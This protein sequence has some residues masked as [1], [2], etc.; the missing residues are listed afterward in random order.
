MR[1]TTIGARLSSDHWALGDHLLTAPADIT[2]AEVSETTGLPVGL[3]RTCRWLAR[4]IPRQRRQPG[5][6]FSHHIEVASLPPAVADRLLADAGAA[7][8]SVARLREAARAAAHD[9][10]VDAKV[11]E[12]RRSLDLA[13]DSGTAGW[14]FASRRVER[15]CRARLLDAEVAV[16][17]AEDAVAA[18]ADHPGLTDAHGNRRAAA[19]DRLRALFRPGGGSL[20]LSHTVERL[21]T[22]IWKPKH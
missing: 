11:S 6:S 18:L 7:R 2:D 14:L 15:E 22:R 5:L 9:A 12:A 13:A 4:A 8:W 20:P 21:L 1:C 3:L 17:T 16:R 10:E 19:A